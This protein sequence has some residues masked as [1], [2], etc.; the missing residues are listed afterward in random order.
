VHH[1]PF[2]F[3]LKTGHLEVEAVGPNTVFA[4]TEGYAR[5]SDGIMRVV[6]ESAHD[7]KNIDVEQVLRTK[8][9]A[10]YFLAVDRKNLDKSLVRQEIHKADNKID[11]VKKIKRQPL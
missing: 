6:V 2:M 4:I 3:L 9:R 11:A 5:M 1:V 8:R 10:E 7:A